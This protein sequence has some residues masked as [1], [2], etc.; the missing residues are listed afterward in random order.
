[1]QFAS[2]FK[3]LLMGSSVEVYLFE[4]RADCTKVLV[5]EEIAVSEIQH[6]E[7]KPFYGIERRLCSCQVAESTSTL[8]PAPCPRDT[9][10]LA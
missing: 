9:P 6:M 2:Q 5:T 3:L 4:G 7:H 8:Q 1:M 10:H